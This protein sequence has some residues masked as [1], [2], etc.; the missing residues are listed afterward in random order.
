M[1]GD[2]CFETPYLRFKGT[3]PMI[4]AIFEGD[5]KYCSSRNTTYGQWEVAS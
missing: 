2:P 4:K 3:R 5:G 1:G